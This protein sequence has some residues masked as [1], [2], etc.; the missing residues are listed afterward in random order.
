MWS[1]PQKEA[2]SH[3]HLKLS[4]V[5]KANPLFVPSTLQVSTGLNL[6]PIH[7][8]IA[9]NA[10]VLCSVPK[11]IFRTLANFAAINFY[12]YWSLQPEL[13]PGYYC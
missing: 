13:K 2:N 5:V 10:K 11:E 3:Y 6:L 7:I 4:C 8:K 1:Q 9:I 12:F